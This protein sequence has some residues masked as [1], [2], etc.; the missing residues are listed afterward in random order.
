MLQIGDHI[1]FLPSDFIAWGWSDAVSN[2]FITEAGDELTEE[3]FRDYVD[4]WSSFLQSGVVTELSNE[5]CKVKL[6]NPF[7]H[8][9][10][11]FYF[12]LIPI[13]EQEEWTSF[14]AI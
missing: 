4:N 12:F 3:E 11:I 14:T 8:N 5:E 13:V 10:R 2:G 1:E 6:D 9:S 7:E